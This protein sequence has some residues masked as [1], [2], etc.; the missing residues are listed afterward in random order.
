ME[1]SGLHQKIKKI[2]KNLDNVKKKMYNIKN[3]GGK[4][5]M[6]HKLHTTI[7]HNIKI[8][9]MQAQA[10]IEVEEARLSEVYTQEAYD[11]K[12]KNINQKINEL[13]TEL[14]K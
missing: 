11:E 13:I 4:K 8:L 5:K 9:T 10:F 3:L 7:K 2:S 1:A 6:K 12:L 14:Q